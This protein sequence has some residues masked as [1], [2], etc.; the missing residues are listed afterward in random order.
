MKNLPGV[1][2]AKNDTIEL[3]IASLGYDGQGAGRYGGLVVFVPFALPGER[4]RAHIVKVAR[5]Y[6]VGK[7]MELL[8]PAPDRAVPRCPVFGRCG[9]CALQHMAYP[10]QLAFK[11]EAVAGALRKIGGIE[12]PEVLP[13]IGMAEP[14]RYRNK[15]TFPIKTGDACGGVVAGMYAPRSHRIVPVDDCP[16]QPEAVNAA[17]AAVLRWA[18]ENG[19]QPYGEETGAG[20]LRGVLARSFAETGETLVALVTNGEKLPAKNELIKALKSAVPGLAGIVQNINTE[21]TNVVLGPR[22]KT[23]WGRP[24]AAAGL[25]GLAF[26]VGARSFFQVNT[27]QMERLYAEAAEAAGLTGSELVVDAY[28]GVGTIGQYMAARAG[29]VIGIESVPESVEEAR[30]SAERNGIANAGYVCGRAED[31]LADMA[32][33]G[34]KPD[35]ILMDPP[36]KGCDAKFLEAAAAT[37]ASRLVYVS[38]NP[39]TMAR[40]IQILL[41]KGYE[42]KKVQPVD[43][44][45]QTADVECVGLMLRCFK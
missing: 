10:A 29:R 28:C 37:G 14:W 38:C 7:L 2:I 16:I 40:D 42:L 4:V 39:S 5:G 11:R 32:A 21:N 15:G 22:E 36:R 44:F 13:V 35:V 34:L 26:A 8:R 25:G 12:N 27:E 9:G 33:K 43:M 23:V 24:F 45:P 20:L 17:L 3:D 6:A 30:R 19:V 31:V 18:N 41:E 1:P